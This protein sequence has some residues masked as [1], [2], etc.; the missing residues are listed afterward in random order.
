MRNPPVLQTHLNEE[1]SLK[2][3]REGATTSGRETSQAYG[4]TSQAKR[5][6]INNVSEQEYKKET[7]D[8]TSTNK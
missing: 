8:V 4:E 7:V 1:K 5:Q 6:A 2:R 3:N